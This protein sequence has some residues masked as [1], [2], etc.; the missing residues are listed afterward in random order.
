MKRCSSVA[1]CSCA[2]E[3]AVDRQAVGGVAADDR[4][5]RPLEDRVEVGRDI[6]LIA[7]ERAEQA[8]ERVEQ[9][10]IVVA[11]HHQ[12][13][14]GQHA[15]ERGGRAPLASKIGALDKIARGDQQIGGEIVGLAGDLLGQSHIKRWAGVDIRDVHQNVAH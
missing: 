15:Q 9:R 4:Q 7:V 10:H 8:V 14:L 13:R 3:A 5:A 1:I 12:A 2:Q 6:A 11:G